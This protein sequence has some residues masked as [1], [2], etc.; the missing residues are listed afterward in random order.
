MVLLS[1]FPLVDASVF[2]KVTHSSRDGVVLPATL[3]KAHCLD[4]L[5]L[6]RALKDPARA[7]LLGNMFLIKIGDYCRNREDPTVDWDLETVRDNI[8]TRVIFHLL[9]RR[10]PLLPRLLRELDL[11]ADFG[12]LASLGPGSDVMAGSY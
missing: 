10:S 7:R 5:E 8:S 2:K 12:Q 4:Y 1:K 3:A 6:R 9:Y 11:V